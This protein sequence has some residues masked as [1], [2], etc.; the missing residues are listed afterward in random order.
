MNWNEFRAAAPELAGVADA[1]I[2][3]R[4]VLLLGTL[5]PRR[6]AADQRGRVR[7]FR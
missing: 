1:W 6:L 5:S 7:R 3:E 4:H 2:T